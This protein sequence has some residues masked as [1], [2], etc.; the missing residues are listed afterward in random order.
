MLTIKGKNYSSLKFFDIKF[1]RLLFSP[2]N[3][4]IDA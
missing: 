3:L 4:T 1:A 2:S